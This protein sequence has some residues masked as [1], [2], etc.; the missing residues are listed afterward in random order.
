MAIKRA[1][2][3]VSNFTVLTNEVLRDQRL[4]F[5]ARGI[6]A[7]ILS[8]PD[9]WRSNAESLARE[10]T[11]G[12]SALLTALKEL[13]N[14]GYLERKKHQDE[15]GH[16]RTESII[17]DQP[18]SP[19]FDYPMSVE[20]KSDEPKSENRTVIEKLIKKEPE[21]I[22]ASNVVAAYIDA[23]KLQF[24]SN[25]PSRSI[26]RIAKDAKKMIDEGIDV[27]ILINAAEALVSAGHTNL[28][29]S[30]TWLLTNKRESPANG[31]LKLLNDEIQNEP[32]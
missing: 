18:N 15:F 19:K 3:P 9:N 14:F 23:F 30:Y 27:Q 32:R 31:W 16:W 22:N 29:A 5:R 17:Y 1:P 24:S 13:E 25:P 10:T 12:R 26:G 28:V 11:E 6:L 20:P 7:S 21:E 2:R 4:S 8:R